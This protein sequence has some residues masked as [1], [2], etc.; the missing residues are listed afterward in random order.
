MSINSE[1]LKGLVRAIAA[2][3]DVEIGCDDCFA[4]IDRFVELHLEGKNAA[5]AL[6]LVQ[7]H[8]QRCRDCRE[9][10][11][12]LLLALQASTPQ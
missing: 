4:E 8:L 12:A 10:F 5:E 7:A 11:N 1:I 6:P 3:Q 9:E 2:T